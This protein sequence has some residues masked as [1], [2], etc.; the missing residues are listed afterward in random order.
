MAECFAEQPG[1][2]PCQFALQ[3]GID[4][5]QGGEA[6]F[7]CGIVGRRTGSQWFDNTFEQRRQQCRIQIVVD[8]SFPAH[9]AGLALRTGPAHERAALA[10]REI[11]TDGAGV[12]GHEIAVDERRNPAE[13]TGGTK[14]RVLAARCDLDAL[15]LQAKLGDHEPDLADEGR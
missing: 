14:F 11:T 12:I 9:D 15:A 5:G 1:S 8:P 4:V 10:H 2:A 3:M 7:E 13:R 6:G